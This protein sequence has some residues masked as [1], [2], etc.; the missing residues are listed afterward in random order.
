MDDL[1]AILQAELQRWET[2]W[3]V[4]SFGAIG[5]FHQDAGEE[6]I[7]DDA[8]GLTRATPRGAVRVTPRAD[9]Q[10]VAY[11]L[12]SPRPHR[13]SQGI[14]L[15][16]P[17]AEAPRPQRSV[18]TELGPDTDAIR[19]NDRDDILFDIGLAQP[20]IDFCVRTRD[21]ELLS[22]LRACCGRPTFASEAG[23][24]IL[25]FHPHRVVMS[26]LGRAEVYQKIGG[27]DTGGVSPP[28]PHTHVLPKLLAAK[29]THSANTPIPDGLVPCLF[30]HPANPVITS[31]GDDKPFDRAQFERFQAYLDR[32]GVAGYA[33]TKT[34]IWQAIEADQGPA[35]TAEPATRLERAALRNALRQAARV[36]EASG[37][38]VRAKRVAAWRAQFDKA[39]DPDEADAA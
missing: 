16:L 33:Q 30:L 25:A 27:P 28:G 1:I 24:A 29:R 34:R 14:A 35:S 31:L 13:W 23:H 17:E 37:D 3:S 26:H 11:E 19:P 20:Q 18:L 7:V 8:G 5:E 38:L 32:Y 39:D 21:P 22:A 10:A 6:L 12:L 9:M 2:G 4:G 15:C 36:A